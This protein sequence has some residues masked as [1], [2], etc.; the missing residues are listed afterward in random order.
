MENSNYVTI[1]FH[2]A[3]IKIPIKKNITFQELK[4][5]I[6][7][8]I[9]IHPYFQFLY[10]NRNEEYNNYYSHYTYTGENEIEFKIFSRMNIY[11]KEVHKLKFEI[12]FGFTFYLNIKPKNAIYNI[13]D[14]IIQKFGIPYDNLYL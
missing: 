2:S 10:Y 4:N 14:Q 1:I 12:E 9:N 13:T 8:E 11:L 3:H 7:K 6:Y 5:N